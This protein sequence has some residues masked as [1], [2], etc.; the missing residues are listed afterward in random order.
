[1]GN[2][3][4]LLFKKSVSGGN[5]NVCQLATKRY[6]KNGV[7]HRMNW[8]EPQRIE[9][10]FNNAHHGLVYRFVD[11]FVKGCL[12]TNSGTEAGYAIPGSLLSDLLHERVAI[13]FFYTCR[14]V[15]H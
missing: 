2:Q 4:P 3:Q 9:L 14:S 13:L 12:G 15:K 5:L 8:Y 10:R 6:W 1:M 7:T 11:G